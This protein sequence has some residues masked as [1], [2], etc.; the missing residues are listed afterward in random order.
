MFVVSSCC[1]R[2]VSPSCCLTYLF[3]RTGI[4]LLIVSG[5]LVTLYSPSWCFGLVWKGGCAG[6][7]SLSWVDPVVYYFPVLLY[8]VVLWGLFCRNGCVAPHVPKYCIERV[9][10]SRFCVELVYRFGFIELMHRAAVIDQVLSSWFPVVSSKLT[11]TIFFVRCHWA[12]CGW[13]QVVFL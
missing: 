1:C 5:L 9:S 3:F 13:S 7:A 10:S 12:K 6:L 8:R 2:V 11:N 4:I